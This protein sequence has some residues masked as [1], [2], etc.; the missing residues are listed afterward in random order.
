MPNSVLEA[1]KMGIWDFE[2]ERHEV[3]H[4]HATKALP[5]SNEKLAVLTERVQRGLPL[6][7]PNDRR[8]YD[9]ASVES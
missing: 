9:D 2:P 7:H 6:W 8:S 3:N 1:I 4:F 5:G